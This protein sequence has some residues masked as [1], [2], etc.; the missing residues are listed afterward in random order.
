MPLSFFHNTGHAPPS[1]APVM[2]ASFADGIR[3]PEAH[4]EPTHEPGGDPTLAGATLRGHW[5]GGD[6]SFQ[7]LR[8]RN[9]LLKEFL[10]LPCCSRWIM[11]ARMQPA[12]PSRAR[13]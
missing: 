11:Q 7:G 9:R 1:H 2:T 5:R 4:A 13:A 3:F 8:R 10:S 12:A 6:Y